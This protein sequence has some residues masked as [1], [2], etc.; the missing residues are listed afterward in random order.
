[1]EGSTMTTG[2]NDIELDGVPPAVAELVDRDE[3]V[4]LVYRLGVCLDEGRFDDMRTLFVDD[5]VASTPGGVADGVDALI[6][7]ASRNHSPDFG[8]QH[9]IGNVLVDLQ[10]DRATVRANLVV[11]FARPDAEPDVPSTLGEVYRFA[12]RRSLAGW[13][14]ARVE[15]HPV[16]AS[17][18][19]LELVGRP[20]AP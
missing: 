19:R 1:M 18:T 6:A 4:R 8:I 14:L 12:A 3:I 5:A 10:G 13:R 20:A 17:H 11:T 7:Q 16:W 2:S 15:S 9:L